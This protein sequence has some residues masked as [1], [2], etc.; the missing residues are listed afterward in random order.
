M[1]IRMLEHP[2]LGSLSLETAASDEVMML[3]GGVYS[4]LD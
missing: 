4:A 3:R 1:A 2:S